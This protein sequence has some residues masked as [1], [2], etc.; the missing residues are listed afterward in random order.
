MNVTSTH[1]SLLDIVGELNYTAK[2]PALRSLTHS[3]MAKCIGALRA[4]IRDEQRFVRDLERAQIDLDARNEV[5]ES[6]RTPNENAEAM[7]F[8]IRKKPIEEASL[9]HAAYDWVHSE[10]MT[11]VQS[12]W[13]EPLTPE[14]MI[15]YMIKNSREPSLA[16]MQAL[17]DAAKVDLKTIKTFAEVEAIRERD[18]LIAARPEILT[19]FRGFGGNG[20]ETAIDELPVLVQ[21]QLGV[22]V[23]GSLHKAR[24]GVLTRAL[25]TKRI[26]ELSA[27]PL[28]E[29]GVEKISLWVRSFELMYRTEINEAI[30]AGR[31]VVS[32]EDLSAHLA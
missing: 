2:I 7:G 15:D 23:V 27:I 16:F 31:Q 24:D 11:R 32:L 30:A 8:E 6:L 22:K 20:Y 18:Q 9:Y 5:D 19:L 4:H 26:S 1:S 10:L 3:T 17:A 21:H 25:R 12:M 29:D 14:A 28:I 13:E